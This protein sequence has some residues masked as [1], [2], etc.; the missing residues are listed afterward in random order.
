ME[1][2]VGNTNWCTFDNCIVMPTDMESTC[3]KELP[4]VCQK[5]ESDGL[6]LLCI[7]DHPKPNMNGMF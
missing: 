4:K 2:R 7:H 6:E 5:I 3:C 1:N